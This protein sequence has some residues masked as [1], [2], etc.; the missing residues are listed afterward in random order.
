MKKLFNFLFFL[1]ISITVFAQA[2][3]RM[4]YQAVI[5]NSSNTLVANQAVGIRVSIIKGSPSGIEVYKEIFNPNPLT[6]ANG[7]VSI[8]IGGGAVI[9][10]TFS[11]IN[12]ANGPYYLKTETDP[13]GGTNYTITGI[14][15]LLSVPYALQS[16]K[17]QIASNGISGIAASGD[18]LYLENGTKLLIPGIRDVTSFVPGSIVGRW[19]LNSRRI[20][21]FSNGSTLIDTTIN[22]V[23]GEWVEFTSDGKINQRYYDASTAS[24]VIQNAF[25]T[26]NVI[27]GKLYIYDTGTPSPTPEIY[28]ILT[29]TSSQLTLYQK[30]I[31]II[32]GEQ[33]ENYV[34]IYL[35]R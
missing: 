27:G 25:A 2:P 35:S 6:N 32:N 34:W 26:Y 7:L 17:S 19:N 8:E 9:T 24:F 16:N 1:L 21:Y 22:S 3:Q 5:R 4:T 28:D 15:Q 20:K 18:T 23:P 33:R 30:E 13:T 31:E 12:W 11:N 14:S 10:G 29:L